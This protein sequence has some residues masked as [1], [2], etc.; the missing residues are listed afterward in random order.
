[1]MKHVTLLTFVD[2]GMGG[3]GVDGGADETRVVVVAA[4]EL[5]SNACRMT[6]KFGLTIDASV[7]S[8]RCNHS[9]KRFDVDGVV[10]CFLLRGAWS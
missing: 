9:V 3:G 1:M 10:S 4:A 8:E 2:F 7:D 6:L 5:A